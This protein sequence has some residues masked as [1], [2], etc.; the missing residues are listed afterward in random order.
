[1]MNNRTNTT[2][3]RVQNIGL[4]PKQDRRPNNE[5]KQN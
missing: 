4:K 3:K 5:T 1:M 2:K